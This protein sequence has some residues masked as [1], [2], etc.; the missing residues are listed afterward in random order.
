MICDFFFRI[1][2]GLEASTR[3]ETSRFFFCGLYT[4]KVPVLEAGTF[5]RTQRCRLQGAGYQIQH[6]CDVGN[7]HQIAF[8]YSDDHIKQRNEPS[9]LQS[10]Q[11]HALPYYTL[12]YN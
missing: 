1:F 10:E 3:I 2:F 7:R 5:E 6:L 8:V 11:V 12:V 4:L 9:V